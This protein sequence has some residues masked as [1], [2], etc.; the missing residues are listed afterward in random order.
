MIDDYDDGFLWND[1]LKCGIEAIEF[2]YLNKRALLRIPQRHRTN[3]NGAISLVHSFFPA[4]G[5]IIVQ[6]GDEV[7]HYVLKNEVWAAK[8][9]VKHRSLSN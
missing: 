1:D 9:T 4:V 3:M 8:E 2:D 6:A 5:W 7:W